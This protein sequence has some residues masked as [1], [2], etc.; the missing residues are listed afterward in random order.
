MKD[1]YKKTPKPDGKKSRRKKQL[2]QD[3]IIPDDVSDT[4]ELDV[5]LHCRDL[6]VRELEFIM[7]SYY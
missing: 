2:Q 6:T 1:L 7:V 5:N 4:I 3:D